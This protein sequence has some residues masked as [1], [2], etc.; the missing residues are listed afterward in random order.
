MT[1]KQL[2]RASGIPLVAGLMAAGAFGGAFTGTAAIVELGLD[3]PL[4]RSAPA[5]SGTPWLT[6]T[7]AD[8][9]RD[10]VHLTLR[11]A[12]LA[13]GEYVSEWLMNLDPSL[14]PADLTVSVAHRWGLFAIPKRAIGTGLEPAAGGLQFDLGFGFTTTRGLFGLRRFTAG[15]EVTFAIRGP[16]GFDVADFLRSSEQGTAGLFTTVACVEGLNPN[17]YEGGAAWIGDGTPVPE[18]ATIVGASLLVGILAFRERRRIREY[19]SRRRPGSAGS[20]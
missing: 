3:T 18:P 2:K 17:L 8:A 15:D 10:T 9:G 6:A 5:S 13:R 20:V 19:C 16:E 11:A 14:N 7:L 4:A 1:A 12:N